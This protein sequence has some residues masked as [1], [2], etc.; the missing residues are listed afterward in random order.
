VL[1]ADH[2][3]EQRAAAIDGEIEVDARGKPC[4]MPVI[5]LAGAV[6][7]ADIGAVVRLLADDPAAKVDVPVWCRMQRQQLVDKQVDGAVYTFRV[8]KVR[9][10]SRA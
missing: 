8:R 2:V 9:E 1:V 6:R 3:E 5:D 7:D 4:P 10:L